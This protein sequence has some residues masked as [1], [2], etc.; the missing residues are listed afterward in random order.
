LNKKLIFIIVLVLIIG[1]V[2][3]VLFQNRTEVTEQTEVTPIVEEDSDTKYGGTFV[4]GRGG[5]SVGLDPIQETDGESFKVAQQIFDTLVD[6]KPGTTEVIPALATDWEVSEDGKVWTMYLREGVKFHDGT[7][8]NAEAVKFNFDRWL[9]EDNEYHMGGEFPYIRYQFGGF[10][11]VFDEINVVDEYTVEF[12]LNTPQGPFLNN[13]AMVCFSI[14]SPTAIKEHGE[15]Y[16]KNPVGTGPFKFV[17]WKKDDRITVEVNEDYWN[18]RAYLDEIIFR[19]IPDP[20]ARFMELQAGSVDMI[21]NMSP[22]DVEAVKSDQKLDLLLRPSNNL[23][24]FSMNFKMPPFDNVKVRKAMNYAIDREAIIG[25]FYAG[26][27]EPAKNPMPPSLWG[28]ND[29]IEAY[30]Y[31]PEK[32]KELLTEAGYPD[33]FEF[34]FWYMPVSRPYFPQPKLIAQSMQGYFAEI[35]LKANLVTYDW[36]TY[37]DKTEHR[38]AQTFLLGWTGDNG[39]PDNFIYALLDK[40][41]ARNNYASE[42]LH[43]VLL[44]AQASVDREERVRLYR[45]AQEIIYADAPWVPVVHSTPPLAKKLMINNYIANP[46]GTEK[47]TR[48]WLDQ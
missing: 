39:D 21:D 48:V 12:V 19:S 8:F 17:E 9:F 3:F 6:Y 7:P 15:D 2:S 10:P 37:L 22:E 26:L 34:D 1:A 29:D 35:G 38:E 27:G 28:Y 44:E 16:F 25:A 40:L 43:N 23:G 20:A 14:S 42:E 24:Y 13:L 36:G 33:G 5:D 11:G 18:G 45:E 32:A 30:D 46:T 47:F 31:N 41:N 4:F